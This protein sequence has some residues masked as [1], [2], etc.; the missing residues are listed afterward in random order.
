LS[1]ASPSGNVHAVEKIYD[2]SFNHQRAFSLGVPMAMFHSAAAEISIKFALRDFTLTAS[3]AWSS[4]AAAIGVAFREILCGN[5]LGALGKHSV[6]SDTYMA[7]SN[8]LYL[9]VLGSSVSEMI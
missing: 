7:A 8:W 6:D 5:V 1:W 3:T 4:G 2:E 9:L